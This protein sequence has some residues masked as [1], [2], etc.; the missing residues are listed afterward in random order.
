M[1]S[2]IQ[3]LKLKDPVAGKQV[4]V[5]T[6]GGRVNALPRPKKLKTPK[7]TGFNPQPGNTSMDTS[8]AA[9]PAD[10]GVVEAAEGLGKQADPYYA[11]KFLQGRRL[12]YDTATQTYR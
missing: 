11:Q 10:E 1:R 7:I 8:R 3:P 9:N 2:D 6:R 5:T 12:R 4:P